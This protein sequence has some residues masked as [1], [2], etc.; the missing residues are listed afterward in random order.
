MVKN[1]ISVIVPVY[2]AEKFIDR[3]IK[4]I[5]N[6]NYNDFEI[7][8]VDDGSPDKCPKI[9]DEW[10]EKD[11]RIKV[12]HKING[13]VSSA[14][15]TGLKVAKGEFVTFVDSDDTLY[16]CALLNMNNL[17][18]S[19]TDF[20]ICSHNDV[21]IENVL[22]KP[23]I[24]NVKTYTANE[25]K[26]DKFIEFDETVWWPWGKLFRMSII[27]KNNLEF[28]TNISFGEDHIFNLLY[29]KHIDKNVVI[30]DIVAYNYYTFTMGLC[31]KIYPNYHEIQKYILDR[32][33]EFF[34]TPPK[35]YKDYFSLA[36]FTGVIDYYLYSYSFNKSIKYISQTLDV[37][38]SCINDELISTCF[39]KKQI[40]LLKAGK[41]KQFALSYLLNNPDKTIIRKAKINGKKVLEKALDVL[42]K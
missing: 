19:E 22:V 33:F 5:L 26:T 10:A 31:S 39:T 20:V 6:Q 38:K 2:N 23:Y 36:Y 40:E 30:S 15:N 13:G 28:D 16:D 25:I 11:E 34:D 32:L 17:M 27:K 21:K 1:M 24:E 41:T 12:I 4:S 35:K 3:C 9:C 29:A 42:K 37:F 14:R 7:I 8:L 18:D